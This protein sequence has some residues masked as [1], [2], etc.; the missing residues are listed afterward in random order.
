MKTKRLVI[1]LG[2]NA[3]SNEDGTLN[4][5]LLQHI[6]EQI[7]DISDKWEVLIVTSGAVGSGRSLIKEKRYDDVTN[8]QIY[9]AV[10]QVQLMKIYSDFFGK[11]NKIIGQILA[12]KLDFSN[13]THYL[14][15][16]NCLESL[17]K[18]SIIPILNENDVVSIK[19]LMFTDNDELAAL[20]AKM[21]C[22][23]AFIIMSNVDGVYDEKGDIIPKFEH[24]D[25]IPKNIAKSKEKS[26]F[27]RGGMKTK[28][29]MAKEV[30]ECGTIV[31]IANSK[32]KNLIPRLLNGEQIGTCF[33]PRKMC[34]N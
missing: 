9:A 16:K 13:R 24:N 32:E 22:T 4:K 14:N 30:A 6:I 10:G 28:F 23:D 31:Y 33:L 20:V 17:F 11:H 8:K 26:S 1:K 27:G 25:A 2:T 18:E 15:M 19:E 29:K 3:I 12:T 5:P 7:V 34:C 21:L